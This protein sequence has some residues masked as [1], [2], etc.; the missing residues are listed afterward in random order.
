MIKNNKIEI[1]KAKVDFH[2]T[3]P[4]VSL[5][6][7]TSTQVGYWSFYN[8]NEIAQTTF[9]WTSILFAAAWFIFVFSYMS[10]HEKLIDELKN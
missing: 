7:S 8:K 4:G 5:T 2:K 1:L 10:R 6:A 9:F 3:W